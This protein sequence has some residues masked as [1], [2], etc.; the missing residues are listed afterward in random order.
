M[1]QQW[2][3]LSGEKIL[4]PIEDE[5]RAV[6]VREKNAGHE[7]KVCIGTD[8]QVKNKFTEFAT[9]IVFIRKGKG[10]FMYIQNELSKQKMSI[11]QRMLMEVAK[12]IETAYELCNIFSR[13]N[14]Q[15][16]VHADINTNPNFKSNDALKEA[17]GY[18]M[19]MGFAFK[20]KPY[21]FASSSCANK[22]VQ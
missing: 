18:I 11:K 2:R 21:A 16:E 1:K 10:G 6:I 20:A 4:R 13:Y 12:S 15:M 17:M 8:S 9:V 14:V 7:L 19:G 3:K 5:I 22:M